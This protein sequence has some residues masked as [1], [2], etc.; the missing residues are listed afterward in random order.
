MYVDLHFPVQGA[1][2]ASDH[3]YDLYAALTRL[4][5][6]LHE[7]TCKIRIGPI[8]GTYSGNGLLHLDARFSRL[9]LRVA[10]E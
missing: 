2:L 7:E 10:S 6:R 5:P 4:L 8:R 9:R 1:S 3:G